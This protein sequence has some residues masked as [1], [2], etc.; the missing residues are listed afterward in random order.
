MAGPIR[1]AIL[2]NGAAARR[3]M[4]QTAQTATGMGKVLS[5]TG[6][7]VA[8]LFAVRELARA[9]AAFTKVGSEYV[10]SLNKIQA[11]TG[12][13]DAVM[14]RAA[15][16][17]E[18]NSGLYAK[19][20]QTTGDAA[21]GVVELTKAGLSLSK[22]LKAV[23]AT[24][25]LA[26]AG[27]L[28]VAD[29]STLVSNTLNT[30]NLK[31]SQAGKIAN[32]LANAANISSADVS[33]LAE[34]F[35]FVAPIAAKSGVSLDQTNAI[36]A[37]LSNSGIKA[38]NAGTGLRK[39]LLSLQA[40]VGKAKDALSDLNVEVYDA[41]G[42]T[43]PLT[44]IIGDLRESLKGLSQAQQNKALRDIFGLTGIT[45]AQVILKNGAKGLAEYTKGVQRAGAAQKLANAAS[46]GLMGT[47]NSLKASSISLAQ[48]LYRQF[49]PA[50]DRG[51]K[52]LATWLSKNQDEIGRTA[53]TVA[54]DLAPALV[55]LARIGKDAGKAFGDAAGPLSRVLLPALKTLGQIVGTAADALDA[56]PDPLKSIAVQAGIAAL[57]M[58]RLAAGVASA[59]AAI[60]SQIT[61]LR[62]LK[63]EMTDTAARSSL[64]SGG[65]ARMGAVLRQAAGIG[66]MVAL[67]SATAHT[68]GSLADLTKQ[69]SQSNEQLRLVKGLAGGAALGFSLFGPVGALVGGA[70]GALFGMTQNAKAA[71]A[72]SKAGAPIVKSYAGSFNQL[73]G[74]VTDATKSTVRYNLGQ[75]SALEAG[76]LL[77]LNEK[78]IVGAVLGHKAAQ[79]KVNEALEA[80]N[81]MLA[82]GTIPH[83]KNG[84]DAYN[85]LQQSLYGYSTASSG[86]TGG[87]R[88]DF[89]QQAA[90]AKITANQVAATK[91]VMAKVP[92][93]VLTR[94]SAPGA[95]VTRAQ[96][97][98]LGARYKLTPKEIRTLAVLAGVPAV[99]AGADKVKG[100]LQ[101]A[102]RTKMDAKPF[103]NSVASAIRQATG[104]ARSQSPAV[105][106]ALKNGL[107]AG[108]AG[109]AASAASSA[110]AA[111]GAAIAAARARAK[112]KS[113]SRETMRLGHDLDDGLAL[114]IR[115]RQ[116][117]PVA[118]MT[119]LTRDLLKAAGSGA[120][121]LR[122]V[123]GKRLDDATKKRL[124]ALRK[125]LDT[126]T[127]LTDSQITKQVNRAQKK[128]NRQTKQ[129]IAGSKKQRD[130]LVAITKEQAAL[131][132]GNFLSYVKK[133]SALYVA[134]TRAGVTNLTDAKQALADLVQQQK[135][136]AAS[137]RD[138]LVATADV[139]QLLSGGEDEVAVTAQNIISAL[140][141][142]VDQ[143]KQYADIIGQLKGEKLNNTT[144]QQILDAGVTGGLATAQALA[145][146]GQEAVDQV[147]AL[148]TELTA[149]GTALGVSMGH[150]MFDAGVSAAQGLVKGLQSQKTEIDAVAQS[151]ADALVKAVRKGLKSHSPS[152]EFLD[153]GKDAVAGLRLGLDATYVKR[154]G[155]VLASSLIKG[156]GEPQLTARTAYAQAQAAAGAAGGP[157][158]FV[159]TAEQLSALQRGRAVTGEAEAF[160]KAGGRQRA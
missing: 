117:A 114:G 82:N 33:D 3:E 106:A 104:V 8:G 155:E 92:K 15:T 122:D 84:V 27:E 45:S 71:N 120:S 130:A 80:G 125:Y 57:V 72:A 13:S 16:Q 76:R 49:S 83:L 143:A 119:A 30:F 70:G 7:L 2:A 6:K 103:V 124:D 127:K 90:A 128:F 63:L 77:G 54:H 20:G 159:F 87:V 11:L 75:T 116:K 85:A 145:A 18:S 108:M 99:V 156:F 17:L 115:Q 146:G 53:N 139:T 137:I 58:P 133:G 81:L 147:N 25:T 118:A 69:T 153:I 62:V 50:V 142:K 39:F 123:I 68:N 148:T 37:E 102:G 38:T 107:L 47:I 151:L 14:R 93:A 59:T 150:T 40:P 136:Y 100:H 135:D 74:A 43:R 111:V 51:L 154:S 86:V 1:I 157:Q 24:M 32:G 44:A 67:M 55:G 29:A 131:Q 5:R 97:E 110:A 60:G 61:Y 52:P 121:D 66:G 113:P 36:L 4:S 9:G 65:V 96:I 95:D 109:M 94:I 21:T 138:S 79:D 129:I 98:R 12:S 152:L 89:L 46:K 28:S 112:A 48:S 64:V 160:R 144:L 132:D 31:A 23:N 26:K 88:Y 141:T 158:T 78:Q 140:Q 56:I 19:M 34:S 41:A 149:T 22:S 134:M 10:D 35:K 126:H 73:T 105:G 42:K 91:A 101:A